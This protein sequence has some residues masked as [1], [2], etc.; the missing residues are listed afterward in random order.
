MFVISNF[1]SFSSREKYLSCIHTSVKLVRR[2][3]SPFPLMPRYG[4]GRSNVVLPRKK[5][6]TLY[7]VITVFPPSIYCHRIVC[8][9][10]VV[11]FSDVL[12]SFRYMFIGA[13][14]VRR[15]SL[16]CG[17]RVHVY[18]QYTVFHVLATLIIAMTTVPHCCQCAVIL[19]C[20]VWLIKFIII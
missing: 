3:S 8:I 17:C 19:S 14:R 4:V 13:H 12:K 1:T 16:Q 18:K 15:E 5:M 7:E 2:P 20:I 9:W 10:S 6:T 11:C